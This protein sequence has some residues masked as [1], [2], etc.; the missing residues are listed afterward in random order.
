MNSQYEFT[1]TDRPMN[2][3]QALQDYK[4]NKAVGEVAPEAPEVVEAPTPTPAPAPEAV[5][6]PAPA[7]APAPTPTPAPAPAP[8]STPAPADFEQALAQEVLTPEEGAIET[9]RPELESLDTETRRMLEKAASTYR[10][11]KPAAR[12]AFQKELEGLE[13]LIGKDFDPTKQA[14]ISD[15]VI[16]AAAKA[17]QLKKA[18]AEL[19]KPDSPFYT[20]I[21][22]IPPGVSVATVI[23]PEQMTNLIFSGRIT[24]AAWRTL[25]NDAYDAYKRG[26]TPTYTRL[27][28]YMAETRAI[29]GYRGLLREDPSYATSEAIESSLR[30]YRGSPVY[31]EAVRAELDNIQ[32]YIESN[33]F[34]PMGTAE[35]SR[36]VMLDSLFNNDVLY[37]AD[38]RLRGALIAAATYGIGNVTAAGLTT[39]RHALMHT[40][41]R[42]I[43]D[44]TSIPAVIGLGTEIATVAPY[45]EEMRELYPQFATPLTVAEIGVGLTAGY[46]TELASRAMYKGAYSLAKHMWHDPASPLLQL[47]RLIR[48]W[49]VQKIISH[50][51]YMPEMRGTIEA[52]MESAS[53]DTAARLAPYGSML[54]QDGRPGSY[55]PFMPS[56]GLEHGALRNPEATPVAMQR[57]FAQTSEGINSIIETTFAKHGMQWDP[58]QLAN[59]PEFDEIYFTDLAKRAELD[60]INNSLVSASPETL[61]IVQS[62]SRAIA[63]Q[64][65]GVANT[66]SAS[67]HATNA[68]LKLYR[69]QAIA[70]FND[71]TPSEIP[72][73]EHIR[74]TFKLEGKKL[75]DSPEILTSIIQSYQERDIAAQTKNFRY[76]SVSENGQILTP[77]NL[78]EISPEFI[79]ISNV[80]PDVSQALYLTKY[81]EG[82]PS[83]MP[84]TEEGALAF[85]RTLSPEDRIAAVQATNLGI[86]DSVRKDFAYEGA[87]AKQLNEGKVPEEPDLPTSSQAERIGE[88]GAPPKLREGV[89]TTGTEIAQYEEAKAAIRHELMGPPVTDADGVTYYPKMIAQIETNARALVPL[90]DEIATKARPLVNRTFMAIDEPMAM[91]RKL[92]EKGLFKDR[93][94]LMEQLMHSGTGGLTEDEKLG[95]ARELLRTNF[96]KLVQEAE[97]T[98]PMYYLMAQGFDQGV[99]T[100]GK[101]IDSRKAMIR[102]EIAK[103]LTGDQTSI[104]N[105]NPILKHAVDSYEI[106][107]T[108][109][110]LVDD[111]REITALAT[112]FVE[113][114]ARERY[115]HLDSLGLGKH[116][117][118]VEVEGRN[119]GLSLQSDTMKH[120]ALLHDQ[121]HN[122]KL[123]LAK[124][125]RPIYASGSSAY[126]VG[127][128]MEDAQLALS[129]PKEA[130]MYPK[131]PEEVVDAGVQMFGLLDRGT[132][133]ITTRTFDF[134][135]A[136]KQAYAD[137]P[138][139]AR[140]FM[141]P[142][143][144]W[145]RAGQRATDEATPVNEITGL[146]EPRQSSVVSYAEERAAIDFAKSRLA[147]APDHV[148]EAL[149]TVELSSRFGKVSSRDIES[150]RDKLPG[151]LQG[152]FDMTVARV[153]QRSTP[154]IDDAIAATNVVIRSIDDETERATV[155]RLR[156]EL[157]R[158]E[159]KREMGRAVYEGADPY[160]GSE[161][162]EVAPSF[163][164]DDIPEDPRTARGYESVAPQEF[165]AGA[166]LHRT[167]QSDNFVHELSPEALEAYFRH[168]KPRE[169]TVENVLEEFR[170][171]VQLKGENTIATRDDSGKWVDQKVDPSIYKN[172]RDFDRYL[173]EALKEREITFD[174][175][176]QNRKD[177][178]EVL[179]SWRTSQTTGTT[180][181][182]GMRR[183][184][185]AA[186][187]EA[188]VERI[189]EA[190]LRKWLEDT[191]DRMLEPVEGRLSSP[192]GDITLD[193]ETAA[194]ARKILKDRLG[195][196]WNKVAKAYPNASAKGRAEIVMGEMH[197]FM[198]RSATVLSNWKKVSSALKL[199]PDN[200]NAI[201]RELTSSGSMAEEARQTIM[202]AYEKAPKDIQDKYRAE[203]TLLTAP[204]RLSRAY[205]SIDGDISARYSL[206]P[207]M[208][209]SERL[210]PYT[211]DLVLPEDI[212]SMYHWLKTVPNTI[213]PVD[214]YA[215]I[216]AKAVYNRDLT[217]MPH[218]SAEDA[219]NLN[220]LVHVEQEIAAR[221][222]DWLKSDKPLEPKDLL[223]NKEAQRF[224]ATIRALAHEERVYTGSQYEQSTA[225]V[226]AAFQDMLS[227]KQNLVKTSTINNY[228]DIRSRL[229]ANFAEIYDMPSAEELL[230]PNI[231]ALVSELQPRLIDGYIRALDSAGAPQEIKEL[232]ESISLVVDETTG[233]YKVD[234][235]DRVAAQLDNISLG[236]LVGPPGDLQQRLI[237]VNDENFTRAVKLAG[238]F[239][240]KADINTNTIYSKMTD[241]YGTPNINAFMMRPNGIE[242][243]KDIA[244]GM[245]DSNFPIDKAK[246][247][248][249]MREAGLLGSAS[250]HA[251]LDDH[252]AMGLA[253]MHS[254]LSEDTRRIAMKAYETA[255]EALNKDVLGS[256]SW[257]TIN[258][259]M[260]DAIVM[261][262]NIMTMHGIR[263]TLTNGRMSQDTLLAIQNLQVDL[264]S[265]AG[266]V[267]TL[268]RVANNVSPAWTKVEQITGTMADAIDFAKTT[269][270]ALPD[271]IR[272]AQASAQRILQ[273]DFAYMQ[274]IQDPLNDKL[275]S[276][277]I[278]E[279]AKYVASSMKE[280]RAEHSK[281]SK[282]AHELELM[283][284]RNKGIPVG[285]TGPA[286]TLMRG[287]QPMVK[288]GE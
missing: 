68:L 206:T 223:T 137:L 266:L 282:L 100:T 230:N 151:Q 174:F 22:S 198:T 249:L 132:D 276:R 142:D 167:E 236:H 261:R 19:D 80:S 254:K 89:L 176:A 229:Y 139:S 78:A 212:A 51:K 86:P 125:A 188:K 124:S 199:S 8:T 168:L 118:A 286:A 61:P 250:K 98:L 73:V 69:E 184:L 265:P 36:M 122:T 114:E 157:I 110:V 131:T 20:P 140:L 18:I 200:A 244:Y 207:E 117:T 204:G 259:N 115:K 113:Q 227:G 79:D 35:R 170:S 149:D 34:D 224:F 75:E 247:D 150:V 21:S 264:G 182:R 55:R 272:D 120:A 222:T 135:I 154:T 190:N 81:L 128:A 228:L 270:Q 32:G 145:A 48:T 3:Y 180:P 173:K 91:I 7:P 72:W 87:V 256:N 181:G 201:E 237:N 258:T 285:P 50:S 82:K 202:A 267:N 217:L 213:N 30:E 112:T 221:M 252:T 101:L 44:A 74:T 271:I 45:Y 152:I 279:Y 43:K 147:T 24:G 129:R 280:S 103:Y 162:D 38:P 47:D 284:M 218:L 134:E 189:Y 17:N 215:N 127:K 185:A 158:I 95:I 275:F 233:G 161:F 28:G 94:D 225:M 65:A 66:K 119:I 251:S 281:I 39:T 240:D 287:G 49:H 191:L 196:I 126:N 186:K 5:E 56:F 269:G 245:V 283:N 116:F 23:S 278:E 274:V 220:T 232:V 57:Q 123:N 109:R 255:Q 246:F 144:R 192:L 211:T 133:P 53:P 187:K 102:S 71:D 26:D 52:A 169:A 268:Y 92:D 226:R 31:E 253:E 2:F 9:P 148:K 13:A 138:A 54:N 262:R 96:D 85:L 93:P 216:L 205:A 235:P 175:S 172:F 163:S 1:T 10:A 141:E 219:N 42:F 210:Q 183:T 67:T 59:S 203:V 99:G 37:K 209:T 107:G 156:D 214:D 130:S 136:T 106:A 153:D 208:G 242:G 166:E 62:I 46:G 108:G 77:E 263:E 83:V 164:W 12:E 29:E 84:D 171:A 179:R 14:Y 231:N 58:K 234:I 15:F 273:Q 111:E 16:Q 6:A 165:E 63:P 241:R 41:A 70:E 97:E 104:I 27:L 178:L 277:N 260:V 64:L 33:D 257:A 288:A 146:V 40:A 155:T 159:N 25:E 193:K 248:I 195:Q 105:D 143:A 4:Q 177:A 239:L 243:Y 160:F 194:S 88:S 76:V 197:N 90:I 60:I 11:N 238:V 121:A